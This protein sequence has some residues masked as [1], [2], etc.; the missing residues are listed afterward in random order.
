M[1]LM[2]L[3]SP[4]NPYSLESDHCYQS[5]SMSDKLLLD[6]HITSIT[7]EVPDSTEVDTRGQASNK[8]WYQERSKRMF[9]KIWQNMQG[10]KTHQP[11]EIGLWL[12]TPC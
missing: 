6:N 8:Q 9:V 11:E 12:N 2:Q 7:P 3:Y 5:D 4:A 1:P 10:N